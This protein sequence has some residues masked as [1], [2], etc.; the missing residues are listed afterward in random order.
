MRREYQWLVGT[1]D[2]LTEP[3]YKKVQSAMWARG[4]LQGKTQLVTEQFN[5]C[6][7]R[8]PA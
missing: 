2:S 6:L 5:L 3:G 8:N 4:V 7:T 1:V